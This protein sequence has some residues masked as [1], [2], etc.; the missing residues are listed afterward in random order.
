MMKK[1]IIALFTALAAVM[2]PACS[3]SGT[4]GGTGSGD[5]T[6]KA[7]VSADVGNMDFD[8]TDRDRDG[9]YNE[10]EATKITLSDRCIFVV[11]YNCDSDKVCISFGNGFEYCRAF[12]A[13][14]G[15]VCGAFDVTT[16]V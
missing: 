3:G 2:L 14:C 1:R 8:F 10:P 6:D 11:A 15:R 5:G 16:A 4:G 7:P 13:I 9:S 12:G